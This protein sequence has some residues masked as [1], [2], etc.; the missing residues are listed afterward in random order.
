MSI[1]KFLGKESISDLNNDDYDRGWMD[2]R[3]SAEKEIES[4]QAEVDWYKVNIEDGGGYL[5]SLKKENAELQAEVQS[6]Q[7]ELANYEARGE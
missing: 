6:L 4:L 2:G 3:D 7:W 5:G 1:N